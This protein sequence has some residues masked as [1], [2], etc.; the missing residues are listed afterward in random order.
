MRSDPV[1]G[2]VCGARLPTCFHLAVSCSAPAP[3]ARPLRA[4]AFTIIEI[5]VVIIMLGVLAG[6]IIPRMGSQSTR[7]AARE[8][9][10]IAALISDA[11]QA[12]Q[13]SSRP[14]AARFT[15]ATKRWET[16]T[17]EAVGAEWTLRT[18]QR[19]VEMDA[20]AIA[21][22]IVDNQQRQVDAEFF[23]EFLPGRPRP[24][25]TVLLNASAKAG[26]GPAWQIDLWPGTLNA[27]VRGLDSEAS[28]AAPLD[29]S[30]DLDAAG[31]RST[32]W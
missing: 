29:D 22:V 24:V 28:S 9:D 31:Q 5:I 14:V 23:I 7:Q 17:A 15:P 26:G 2:G 19:P 27:R 21:S 20:A 10:A 12:A 8:A 1:I 11:A 30:I 3:A 18:P 32:P 4:R 25:A 16:M 6:V 13:F